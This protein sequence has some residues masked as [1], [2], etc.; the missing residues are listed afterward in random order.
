MNDGQ[1]LQQ[2]AHML[3]LVNRASTLV[4]WGAWECDLATERLAWTD[5]VY[6]MFGCPL[7]SPLKRA[8]TL[9]RYT[10]RS[11]QEMETLRAQAL[12]TGSGFTLDVCI[13]PDRHAQR[14]VK[15]TASVQSDAGRPV[16]LYG[17]K[18]DITIEREA[19]IQLRRLAENDPLT[20]L[21]NRRVFDERLEAA[22]R[23][24]SDG[25][26]LVLI[27]FDRFKPINDRFGHAAGDAVLREAALR[28]RRL[29][30]ADVLVARIG[31]DEFAILIETPTAP[32]P[33][34]RCLERS[35]RELARPVAWNG[36]NLD[37]SASIGARCLGDPCGSSTALFADADSSLYEAKSS[38]RNVF[39]LF[40]ACPVSNDHPRPRIRSIPA[41]QLC[42]V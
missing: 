38:G 40:G 5:A 41:A 13:R 25:T 30:P 28:L 18:Q 42:P 17:V 4:G 23:R 24:G 8:D 6:T 33:L 27:D 10:D 21:S 35:L 12:R 22:I 20:G 36:M 3:E 9:A 1:T 39:R 29:F 26:A 19:W 11:R 14:W 31:G 7:G 37:V 2:A 16:R 32:A 15:L 34:I